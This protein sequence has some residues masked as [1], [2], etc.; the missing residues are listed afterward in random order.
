M[1]GIEGIRSEE[2]SE[3]VSLLSKT[4][5]SKKKKRAV[6][7]VRK[8]DDRGKWIRSPTRWLPSGVRDHAYWGFWSSSGM[9]GGVSAGDGEQLSADVEGK[10]KDER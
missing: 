1:R 2:E 9:R 5:G 3:P 8:R 10:K 6:A 7:S 4:W